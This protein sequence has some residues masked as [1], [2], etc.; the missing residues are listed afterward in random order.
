MKNSSYMQFITVFVGDLVVFTS[1]TQRISF[2]NENKKEI[3]FN[4][5]LDFK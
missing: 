3:I 1:K 5:S 4:F 2:K